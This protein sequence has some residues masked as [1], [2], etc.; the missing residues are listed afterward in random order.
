MWMS[1]LWWSG[2]KVS[3]EMA[4]VI[5]TLH[6]LIET[7]AGVHPGHHYQFTTAQPR[8]PQKQYYHHLWDLPSIN[9]HAV[10]RTPLCIPQQPWKPSPKSVL[11]SKQ[12]YLPRLGR[13]VCPDPLPRIIP[14]STHLLAW[15]IQRTSLLTNLSYIPAAFCY[16]VLYS[17][18]C[19]IVT[20]PVVHQI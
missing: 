14:C 3:C 15:V 2:E 16:S 12:N 6:R 5:I 18:H 10:I 11:N 13:R 19:D 17:I 7:C 8:Q 9:H 1:S 20:R 4:L